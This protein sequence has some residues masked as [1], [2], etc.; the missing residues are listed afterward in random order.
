MKAIWRG[1]V[2]AESDQAIEVDGYFYFPRD[3][4]RMDLL[5]PATKNESDLECGHGVQFYDVRDASAKSERA[6]WSYEAPHGSMKKV[7]HWMSFWDEV[8]VTS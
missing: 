5:A 2:I 4:V 8:E 6:A 1:Q 7:D 3:A